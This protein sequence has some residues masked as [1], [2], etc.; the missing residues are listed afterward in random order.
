MHSPGVIR[1]YKATVAVAAGYEMYLPLV[2]FLL[3]RP[4]AA[5]SLLPPTTGREKPLAGGEGEFI[6]PFTLI[7]GALGGSCMNLDR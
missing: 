1:D 6:A 5:L 7:G 4:Q 2:S 3:G